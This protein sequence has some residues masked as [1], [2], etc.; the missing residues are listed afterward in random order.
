MK[1]ISI[2]C[3]YI[4]LLTCKYASAVFASFAIYYLRA[5]LF[6]VR[7]MDTRV[8]ASLFSD[9]LILGKLFISNINL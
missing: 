8:L 3:S 6:L 1:I 4:M 5:F 2:A 9:L 7:V